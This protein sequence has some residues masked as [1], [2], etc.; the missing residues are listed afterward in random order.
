MTLVNEDGILKDAVAYLQQ[1]LTGVYVAPESQD[2]EAVFPCALVAVKTSPSVTG[3]GGTYLSTV[4]IQVSIFADNV[5][6]TTETDES[7]ANAEPVVKRGV[8]TILDEC[9]DAMEER[10]YRR[11]NATKPS[12][13]QP[14]GRWYK[15]I[16]Y[17]KKTNTF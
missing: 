9:T 13:H 15:N 10:F 11:Q 8:L 5:Y 17:D 7:D 14:S 6:D 12:F 2:T 3:L 4:T 1:K 16:W